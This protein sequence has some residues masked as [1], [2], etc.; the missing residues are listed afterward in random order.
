MFQSAHRNINSTEIALQ[1]VHIDIT[2]NEDNRKVTA[3]TLLDLSAALVLLIILFSCS[4]CLCGSA[5]LY[6]V[7][8][9]F[10]YYRN[11]RHHR[12]RIVFRHHLIIHVVFLRVQF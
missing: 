12:L 2:L 3:H 1:K 6:S 5:Y 7:V 10:K 8:S 9:W 4:V 11:G